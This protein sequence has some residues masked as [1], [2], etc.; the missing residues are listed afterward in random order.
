M[1]RSIIDDRYKVDSRWRADFADGSIPPFLTEDTG[2][3]G[4]VSYETGFGGRAVLSTGTTSTGDYARLQA[5]GVDYRQFDA[6]A[7]RTVIGHSP[8]GATAQAATSR[9]GFENGNGSYK[10]EQYIN[11]DSNK[12]EIELAAGGSSSFVTVRDRLIDNPVPVEIVMDSIAGEV[13]HRYQ[14]AGS[15]IITSTVP[16]KSSGPYAADVLCQT[17]DTAADRTL[18]IYSFE[19]M[20]LTNNDA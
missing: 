2:G 17:R 20:Y 7:F 1:T 8:D 10:A 5:E 11:D 18:Y 3:G 16:D 19:V 6:V 14:D 9:V 12:G 13:I 15:R 4:S